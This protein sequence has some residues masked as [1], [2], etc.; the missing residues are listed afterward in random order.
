MCTKLNKHF[1]EGKQY[2]TMLER[3][4]HG[5]QQMLQLIQS[6]AQNTFANPQFVVREWILPFMLTF[7]DLLKVLWTLWTQLKRKQQT[8]EVQRRSIEGL[9]WVAGNCF[10]R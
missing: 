2:K 8:I 7:T 1:N 4:A 10:L 3:E 6:R 9:A 5:K